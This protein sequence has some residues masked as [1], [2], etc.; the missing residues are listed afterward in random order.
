[1]AVNIDGKYY[2]YVRNIQNDI[3]ALVDASG[4]TVV[5]YTYD[6]WGKLLSITGSLKDTVGVQNPFRYRGY[7]YDNETGMYYLKNRYYDPDLRRFISADKYVIGT[8]RILPNMYMYCGNNPVN[9][10]D[11]NGNLF[12]RFITAIKKVGKSIKKAVRHICTVVKS[13]VNKIVGV[14]VKNSNTTKR[15][16]GIRG[17]GSVS[18]SHTTSC[19][20]TDGR[21]K[22]I[23]FYSGIIESDSKVY[24]RENGMLV[25]IQIASVG[26]SGDFTADSV[27]ITQNV[28]LGNS[29]L[30]LG[31]HWNCKEMSLGF[32][33]S[34]S[35][36]NDNM[37]SETTV[38]VDIGFPALVFA[39]TVTAAVNLPLVAGGAVAAGIAIFNI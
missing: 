1:M 34:S 30:G 25:G 12:K 24:D 11:E 13:V 14:K 16:R 33:I 36:T 5:N 28:G 27:S 38:S 10:Y 6:S 3:I 21:A 29:S 9:N 15:T 17:I 20:R 19:F 18:V 22:P 23:T 39:L 4:R 37:E 2:I 35:V 7:Y 31:V 8:D 26:L 32:D